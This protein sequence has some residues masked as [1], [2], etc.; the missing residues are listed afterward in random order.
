M[1]LGSHESHELIVNDLEKFFPLFRD[2]QI[3]H[4]RFERHA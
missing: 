4:V 2:M 3:H 1:K